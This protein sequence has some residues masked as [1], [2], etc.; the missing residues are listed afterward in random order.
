MAFFNKVPD[1][2]PE[3][4]SVQQEIKR[5]RNIGWRDVVICLL[6][7]GFF[8]L[9]KDRFNLGV[10]LGGY[11]GLAPVLEET[12]FGITGLDGNTHFFTYVDADSIELHDDL[13]SFDRG[14][15]V[16]GK[17]NRQTV[18]GTY[19]NSEF[20][21]YQLHIQT[22]LHN[23]IVVHAPDGVIVFNLESDDTT[24]ELHRYFH[25]LRDEQMGKTQS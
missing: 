10:G 3:G 19:R 24:K 17:E 15:K 22:K 16:E 8:L 1:R 14:E 9:T 25:E 5:A 7:V 2:P 11:G 12:R 20:G 18:S 6:I 23:Y 21:E 13:Q 4:V